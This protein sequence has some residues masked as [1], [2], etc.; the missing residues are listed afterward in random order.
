MGQDFRTTINS[1]DCFS[2][3]GYYDDGYYLLDNSDYLHRHITYFT[4]R[5]GFVTNHFYRRS[6]FVRN[7]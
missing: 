6:G 5:S 2:K 1:C 7:K 4:P 3:E